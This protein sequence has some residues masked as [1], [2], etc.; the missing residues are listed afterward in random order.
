MHSLS[1]GPTRSSPS[2]LSTSRVLGLLLAI[3]LAH[4]LWKEPTATI[5]LPSSFPL[6]GS[7]VQLPL[8]LDSS[9]SLYTSDNH[10]LPSGSVPVPEAEDS[11]HCVHRRA[12]A[13]PHLSSVTDNASAPRLRDRAFGQRDLSQPSG[14]D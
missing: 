9:Y 8:K 12:E 11:D 5:H 3:L 10:L 7:P 4:N 2:Q 13:P 14:S 6:R 1:L